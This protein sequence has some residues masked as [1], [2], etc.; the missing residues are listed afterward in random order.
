M[1]LDILHPTS[2]SSARLTLGDSRYAPLICTALLATACALAS[3]V[4]ACATP[5]VAFAVIAAATLPLS[6]ALFAV[7]VAWLVNQAIGFGFLN[8]PRGCEHD[9]VGHRDR[10]GGADRNRGVHIGP[11][12]AAP[13]RKFSRLRRGLDRRLRRF[14]ACAARGDTGFGRRR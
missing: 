9:S 13:N 6:V 7:G 10:N 5:F 3:F 14:R 1:P 12:H 4:F 8:Y 11:A 2:A